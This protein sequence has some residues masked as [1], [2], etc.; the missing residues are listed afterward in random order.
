VSEGR[1]SRLLEVSFLV[2]SLLGG[3]AYLA[4]FPPLSVADE[5]GH[6]YRAYAVSSG[7]LVPELRGEFAG[8]RMPVSVSRLVENLGTGEVLL[9]SPDARVEPSELRLA[10]R[11]PLRPEHSHF[12][13]YSTSSQFPFVAYLPQ[14]VGV[15]IGR[16]C[17][18][19]VGWLV[20]LGRLTNLVFCTLLIWLSLQMAPFARWPLLV[21]ALSPMALSSRASLSAD[22]PTTALA[23][24]FL[25]AVAELA[26]GVPQR[27]TRWVLAAATLALCATKLPYALLL[28][29]L[30]VVPAE[31]LR[32]RERL[33]W[34]L[35]LGSGAT[36]LLAFDV[37]TA[38][39]FGRTLRLGS[40]VDSGRQVAAA[41]REPLRF[42]R[43][44]VGDYLDHGDRYVAQLM[45]A[46][47]GW[48]DVKIGIEVVWA[49]LWLFLCVLLVAGWPAVSVTGRQRAIALAIVSLLAVVIP[50]SQYATWTPYRA[51]MI[52]GTQGRYF[53][54]V[55][56]LVVWIL[57]R[58]GRRPREGLL[59]AGVMLAWLLV[60]ALACWRILDRH[61]GPV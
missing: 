46:Q 17:E 9:A 6:F 40:G 51:E 19:P 2:A 55:A 54:P 31:R 29:A 37:W 42:A 8:S 57:H 12:R 48:L 61:Y 58:T 43:I 60:T 27:R 41:V 10:L 49:Y 52:E 22:G 11:T 35:V 14:S 50:A 38:H 4:L 25:A 32:L 30:L 28:L 21:L 1:E 3:V 20:Y 7:D 26:W 36:A 39:R 18:L 53:L 5:P 45:G 44:L 34:W 59:A 24:L 13:E 23:F 33:R 15:G 16:I 56:P 47:L